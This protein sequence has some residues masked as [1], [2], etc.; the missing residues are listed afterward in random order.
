MTEHV[1]S[2]PAL[3]CLE[4][5]P[6][7]LKF[8]RGVWGKVHGA[9]S[10]YRWIAVSPSFIGK[11]KELERHLFIGDEGFPVTFP[12]WR[13]LGNTHYVVNCY[14]SRVQDAEG[15]SGFLEKQ[16]IEWQRSSN[17]PTLL[18]SL[19]LL[20]HVARY[21]DEIWWE[22]S[23]E[24]NWIESDSVVSLDEAAHSIPV[25]WQQIEQSIAQGCQSLAETLSKEMLNDFYVRLLAGQ[26]P[27]VL[28]NVKHSLTA[29][30]LAVLLLPLPRSMTDKLSLTGWMPSK[31]P[32]IEKL[33]HW[34]I[35]FNGTKT[36][37]NT[38]N[39]V[40][41]TTEHHN[42][43]KQMSQ[44]VLANEPRLLKNASQTLNTSSMEAQTSLSDV[45]LTLWGPSSAGKTVYLAQLYVEAVLFNKENWNIYL[46]EES[47]RFTEDMRRQMRY[48]NIFPPATT[49][50]DINNIVYHFQNK[51]TNNKFSLLIEDRAGADYERF[52]ESAQERLRTANGLILLFDHLRG[53]QVLEQ[54]IWDTLG[55]LQV[56]SH[57]TT[58]DDRP[59]A[60][61]L[62]KADI[63]IKSIADYHYAKNDP[64]KFVRSKLDREA[65]KILDHF[66]SN[67][68]F[69]PISSAGLH[70][71]HGCIEPTV[72][73]DE[74]LTPRICSVRQPFNLLAPVAWLSEQL[75]KKI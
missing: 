33:R 15:R 9:R 3:E 1:S 42:Q 18:G 31:Q 36:M 19:L 63:L 65:V 35:I 62:S 29:E 55:K 4:S 54:E 26:R 47:L 21:T 16:V 56:A 17:L 67:Y 70:I 13:T 59:I 49:K 37:L 12:I 25:S 24:I 5:L 39:V 71:R 20:P 40:Y 22:K 61:C 6:Q 34:D 68:H 41:P 53:Q 69:F 38:N 51:K 64:D 27:T 11:E 44:A 52:E 73:F 75:A 32:D 30:A 7:Q 10:D 45:Q 60:V 2:W 48:D 58:K 8:E 23:K 72:F 74:N 43:A 28:D 66:C 14:P 57:L 50:G 46:T